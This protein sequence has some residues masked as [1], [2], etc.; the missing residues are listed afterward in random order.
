MN[1]N[2]NITLKQMLTLSSIAK[3]GSFSKAARFLNLTPPAITVQIKS[4]EQ[5]IKAKVLVR[6]SNGANKLTSIGHE[7]VDLSNRIHNNIENTLNRI[8]S[9]SNGQVGS[10]SLGV[11]STAKYFA[12]WIVAN[13]KSNFSE[14]DIELFV[15]NRNEIINALDQNKI[16]LAIMGRPPRSNLIAA[17]VLGDHPHVMIARPEHPLL[18]LLTK[19][20]RSNEISL[21]ELLKE[22][23]IITRETGS[24]T[25][26]LLDRFLL[27]VSSEHEFK[28]KE[29]SSNETVKQS[30]MAGLGVALISKSTIS[31]ELKDGRLKCIELPGLPIV[32]QW[33]LVHTRQIELNPATQTLREF[34]IDREQ[35]VLSKALTCIL[36]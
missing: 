17:E 29:M 31:A 4:L 13:A 27:Q 34:L 5:A 25:R 19:T 14:L 10:V 33:F 35:N 7:I 8:K 23:I 2:I 24:G 6:S 28:R 1:K 20:S 22:E 21:A 9:I 26:I 30:V 12:P 11:V 3:Q 32:R 15:G 36:A 18:D 16:D